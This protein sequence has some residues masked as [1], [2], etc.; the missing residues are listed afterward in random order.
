M[1]VHTFIN[2]DE[3]NNKAWNITLY[4]DKVKFDKVNFVSFD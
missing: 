1:F 2:S 4:F 3:F